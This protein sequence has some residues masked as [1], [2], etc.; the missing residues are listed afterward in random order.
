MRAD[1]EA[2]VASVKKSVAVKHGWRHIAIALPL[3]LPLA[4]AAA[5]LSGVLYWLAFPGIDLWPVA[6]VAWVPLIVAVRGQT[7]RAATLLGWAAG[8]AMNVGGFSWLQEMLRTFSGFSWL[9]CAA[10]VIIVCAY[11]AGRLALLGWLYARVTARG[12]TAS[13]AFAAAF[14]ASELVYPLL[15]P[16][17][18]AATVH[19]LPVLM[20][21]ADL[22]GPIMTGLVLVA[23][24]LAVTELALAALER[25]AVAVRTVGIGATA[26]A[27]AMGYGA[28]RVRAV[29]A[30]TAAAPASTVGVVQANMSLHEKRSFFDE[31]L[32]RHLRASDD[33][34]ARHADFLVWSET[35]AMRPLAEDHY[36]EDLGDLGRRIGAP[37]IIGAVLVRPAPSDRRYIF[38]NSAISTEPSGAVGGRYDKHYL[39]AFGEYIPLGD[40]FPQ[41][42]RWSPNSGRFSPGTTLAPLEL[43]VHDQRH[44]VTALICYEDVLPGFANDAVRN[45]D[46]D[47][48]VNL[49]NDAWFGDTAEPWEHLALSQFRAVEHHRFLVRG[50]NSGISAVVDPAGRVLAETSSFKQEVLLTTIR[51]MRQRTVYELVGDWLWVFVSVAAAIGALRPRSGRW[52]F[53][54]GA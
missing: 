16:W 31:G 13:L 46:P 38:Y 29:D 9:T 14:V 25:R 24:N 27:V 30:A 36:R 54:R 41:L 35:A 23:F 7:A 50:T 52:F 45:A 44:V 33:L 51:W 1:S 37:A 12:W 17:Y 15:F 42:Y 34:V 10:F 32:Q 47:L 2:K 21:T 43:D 53:A 48:M 39:L 19:R 4:L 20:Q 11:Q 22:G 18:F 5:T 49:T 3:P 26:L 40:L 28:I 6:F 8:F